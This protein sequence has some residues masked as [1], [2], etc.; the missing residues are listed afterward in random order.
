MAKDRL[1]ALEFE[2]FAQLDFL[3]E[4]GGHVAGFGVD[5]GVKARFLELVASGG[6]SIFNDMIRV[7]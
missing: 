6:L 7:I 5:F 3:A 2:E 1:H 4:A